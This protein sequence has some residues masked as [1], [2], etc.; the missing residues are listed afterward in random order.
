M[1][2]APIRRHDGATH[3]RHHN[4]GLDRTDASRPEITSGDA[5][6]RRTL[7]A[8]A[9]YPAAPGASGPRARYLANTAFTDAIASLL[10]VQGWLLAGVSAV[11][12]SALV[13][14][15]PGHGTVSAP[16]RVYRAVGL[17]VVEHVPST[18]TRL[19]RIVVALDQ[20]GASAAV[21]LPDG[22]VAPVLGLKPVFDPLLYQG[23]DTLRGGPTTPDTA[24]R[25]WAEAIVELHR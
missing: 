25:A 8:Q 1:A 7:V 24:A 23:I 16:H 13:E 17:S 18:G 3:G 19:A 22:H 10:G 20:P 5:G 11:H 2:V 6:R 14:V 4:V 12:T 21:T 9:W 15:A